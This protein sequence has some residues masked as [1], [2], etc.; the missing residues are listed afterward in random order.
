MTR[1]EILNTLCAVKEM[2]V[3]AHRGVTTIFEGP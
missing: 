1:D 3:E 2:L